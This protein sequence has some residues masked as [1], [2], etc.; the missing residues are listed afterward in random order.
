MYMNGSALNTIL[1]VI[2]VDLNKPP[3][4]ITCT[5]NNV[6]KLQIVLKENNVLNKTVAKQ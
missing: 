4:C 5:S 1:S 6:I 3:T 2:E